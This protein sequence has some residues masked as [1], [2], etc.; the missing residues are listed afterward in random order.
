MKKLLIPISIVLGSLFTLAQTDSRQNVPLHRITVVTRTT[1]AV[2]YRHKGKS[3]H[4]NFKAP[5]TKQFFSN[6]YSRDS[7]GSC[8]ASKIKGY[9]QPASRQVSFRLSVPTFTF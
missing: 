6:L 8:K 4:V 2:N 9:T 7:H 3:T 5:T 1:S